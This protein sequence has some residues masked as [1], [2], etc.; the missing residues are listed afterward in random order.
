MTWIDLVPMTIIVP[1][2]RYTAIW[3]AKRKFFTPSM[4]NALVDGL[5]VRIL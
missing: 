4:F 2:Q 3:I 5:T 1:F